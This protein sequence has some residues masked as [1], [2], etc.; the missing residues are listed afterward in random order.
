MRLFRAGGRNWMDVQPKRM[1][2]AGVLLENA[3]GELLIVKA[4][5][6]D[7][8][9]LPGGIIEENETP[10]Q[11]AARETLEEVG[12]PLDPDTLVFVSVANRA[13][14]QAHTY[15]FIFRAVL[16]V[17]EIT[18][19]PGELEGFDFVSKDR[20]IAA[21]RRYARAVQDW[22]KDLSGYIEQAFDRDREGLE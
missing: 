1:S 7:Y 12:L 2:S 10:R 6:R 14:A 18:L 5:Y 9:T 22:A 8:W 21:D 4:G 13:S 3:A 11:A 16:P 19:Q 17:S 20:V 15:Q